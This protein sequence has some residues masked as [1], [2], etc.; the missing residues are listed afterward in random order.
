M[1]VS[2]GI[3]EGFSYSVSLI[4]AENLK[5][6][7]KNKVKKIDAHKLK[8]EFVG[9]ADVSKFDI[10]WDTD[11][12]DIDKRK[13]ILVKKSDTSITIDTGLTWEEVWEDYPKD[14]KN[15]YVE[16]ETTIEL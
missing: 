14:D 7:P 16:L 8:E 12:T 5:V 10:Y 11:E 3:T 9:K 15:L 13:I 4:A 2:M 1:Q 6:L